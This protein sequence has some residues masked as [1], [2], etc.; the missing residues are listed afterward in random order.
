MG[1]VR[2]THH[3]DYSNGIMIFAYAPNYQI[4]HIKTWISL[5][6]NN[7]SMKLQWVEFNLYLLSRDLGG[8][9]EVGFH[10]EVWILVLLTC[11]CPS[12]NFSYGVLFSSQVNISYD[13]FILIKCF[14]S[15][16]NKDISLHAFSLNFLTLRVLYVSHIF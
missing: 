6:I 11:H 13:I 8:L 16:P 1:G 10:L 3:F 12:I 7:T 5:C 4:V 2:H 14:L 15:Q 9:T